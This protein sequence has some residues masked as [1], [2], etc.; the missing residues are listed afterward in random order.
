VG[1]LVLPSFFVWFREILVNGKPRRGLFVHGKA[2]VN[3]TPQ[4]LLLMVLILVLVLQ[5][6]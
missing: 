1:T 6:P 5:I 3:G 4:Y 2:R